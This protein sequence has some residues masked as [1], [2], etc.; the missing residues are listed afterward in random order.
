MHWVRQLKLYGFLSKNYLFHESAKFTLK[1]MI[2]ITCQ[3]HDI[4]LRDI[5]K[6]PVGG[7]TRD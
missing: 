3:K 5:T 1:L 6:K 2:L 7:K 4:L